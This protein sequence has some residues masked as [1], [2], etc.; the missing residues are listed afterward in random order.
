MCVRRERGKDGEGEGEE[1][2]CGE[3]VGRGTHW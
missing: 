3:E 2:E 1:A